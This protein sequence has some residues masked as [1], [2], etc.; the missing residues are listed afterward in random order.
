MKNRISKDFFQKNNLPTSKRLYQIQEEPILLMDILLL[1]KIF[2]R[3]E[4]LNNVLWIAWNYSLL[5]KSQV[6][7][8]L[9]VGKYIFIGFIF[10][11]YCIFRCR[12]YL[13]PNLIGI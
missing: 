4:F 9:V 7:I 10:L 12:Y 11:E 5:D 1:C 6:E 13:L 2:T 3:L 8:S